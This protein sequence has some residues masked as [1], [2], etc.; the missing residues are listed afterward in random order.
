[1]GPGEA[2]TL[3][4]TAANAN[5]RQRQLPELALLPVNMPLPGQNPESVS[6]DGSTSKLVLTHKARMRRLMTGTPATNECDCG[7]VLVGEEYDYN[8]E[9]NLLWGSSTNGRTFVCSIK[10]K[11]GIDRA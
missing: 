11:L 6:R 10:A 3:P 1:M 7:L 8:R 4:H 2:N 5:E 9:I